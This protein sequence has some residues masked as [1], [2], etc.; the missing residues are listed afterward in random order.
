[1]RNHL[2]THSLFAFLLS[3]T[4]PALAEEKSA[5]GS[6]AELFWD[7]DDFKKSQENL[8]TEHGGTANQ[9]VIADKFE[10]QSNDLGQSLIFE[11]EGWWGTDENRLRVRSDIE[12][13][14]NSR[15]F[16]EAEVQALWSKPI[17]SFFNIQ[18]GF[19]HDFRPAPSKTYATFGI[20][21]LAPYWFEVEGAAFFSEDGNLSARLG[22][23]YELLLTQR[24]ILQPQAELNFSANDVP[25]LET[26]AGLSTA[27]TGFRLRY[28]F[29]RQFAPYVGVNWAASIGD[30]ADYAKRHN[31]ETE[32]VSVLAGIR[33]WF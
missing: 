19:R 28:E 25:E 26:G 30:T 7:K 17:S 20:Q 14:L 6:Q 16:E 21:G 23:E 32:V 12:Y 18:A 31:D 22:A 5:P 4:F 3:A 29:D 27:E 11:G 8:K 10:Y 15:D 1:M 24:L 13:N 9:F 33:F 2:A